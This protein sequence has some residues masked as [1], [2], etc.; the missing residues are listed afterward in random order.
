MINPFKKRKLL[1]THSG[2]FHADDVFATAILQI[3]LEK[4]GT[5]YKVIRSR[6]EA[7]F[8]RGDFVYDVGGIYDASKNRFDHHQTGKAGMRE[9]EIYYAACGLVWKKFGKDLAG[10]EKIADYLDKKVFQAIDAVDNGQD[11]S[12]PVFAGVFPYSIPSVVGAFN[13]SW[14]EE[15]I[16]ED[17]QFKKAVVFARE[18]IEREIIQAKG[19]FEA[20]KDIMKS[21]ETAKDRH[22]IIIEKPYLRSEILRI[23]TRYSDP[24]Y[25]VYPKRHDG[26]WKIECVRKYFETFESRKLLPAKWAGLKGEKFAKVTGVEDAIF[27]HDGLFFASAQ[28]REGAIM[29]AKKALNS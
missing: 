10:E 23:L 28:S 29:L 21:Y 19:Y 18:I 12:K 14:T 24:V 2:A 9:N 8:A 27:C 1:V 3:Y 13:P 15:T 16:A 25:F 17:D 5:G 4:S 6:D 7:D 11:I 20:E 26:G 22:L